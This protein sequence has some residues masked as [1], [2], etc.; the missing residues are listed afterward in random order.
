LNSLPFWLEITVGSLIII[1]TLLSIWR[2]VKGPTLSDRAVGLDAATTIT[3]VLLVFIA[4][5]S[6]RYIYLDVSLVYGMLA[7]AGVVALA[8]YLEG[9]V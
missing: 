1:A 2:I 3:T 7:F 9:G 5:F 4:Y 8:R 6:N